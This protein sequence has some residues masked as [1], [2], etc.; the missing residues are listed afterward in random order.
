MK[1]GTNK[2]SVLCRKPSKYDS[3]RKKNKGVCVR[4]MVFAAGCTCLKRNEQKNKTKNETKI[5]EPRFRSPHHS[6]I[7]VY[8][9]SKAKPTA[10]KL[11]PSQPT[12]SQTKTSQD[13]PRQVK[14]SQVKTLL[15]KT[16]QDKAKQAKSSQDKTCQ[17]WP[18]HAALTSHATSSHA[19]SSQAK[20][21]S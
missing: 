21:N 7:V 9:Q 18:T 16:R 14:T 2:F 19:T 4:H 11:R 8:L 12:P 6:F 17:A 20:R 13:K 5:H 15:G 3:E 10:T 1:P